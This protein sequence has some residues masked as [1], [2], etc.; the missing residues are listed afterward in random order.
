M[1]QALIYTLLAL[2]LLL[3]LVGAAA[4]RALAARLS[5]AQVAAAAAL[6]MAVAIGSTFTL[7]RGNVDSLRIGDLT[8]LL[9]IAPGLPPVGDLPITDDTQPAPPSD[10]PPAAPAATLAATASI[11]PTAAITTSATL[12]PTLAATATLTPTLAPTATLTPTL[13]ATATLTPTLEPTP[14]PPPPTDTA[15]PAPSQPRTYTVQPG[16]TIRGIAERF[17]V[18]VAA[19][20]RANGLT[21]DQADTI[22][23][24][25]VLTIPPAG[26]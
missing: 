16:D 6:V 19:L 9:P 25:Q 23:P 3:P 4:L 7:V 11:T 10:T 15:A 26:G 17:G 18:T 2:A 5:G 24:G 22:R 8:L 21:A 13:A 12:T 14:A 20:L 1:S